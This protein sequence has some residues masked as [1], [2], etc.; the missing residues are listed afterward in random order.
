MRPT[1]ATQMD[2][3]SEW[4]EF[5]LFGLAG[6]VNWKPKPGSGLRFCDSRALA[7]TSFDNTT[8]ASDRESQSRKRD[9]SFMRLSVAFVKCLPMAAALPSW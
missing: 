9:P 7:P 6:T 1:H 4:R 8:V 5:H 2:W 3:S